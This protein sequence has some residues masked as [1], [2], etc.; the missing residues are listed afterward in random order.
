MSVKGLKMTLADKTS[1]LQNLEETVETL[2]LKVRDR[3]LEVEKQYLLIEKHYKQIANLNVPDDAEATDTS[4]EDTPPD[5][6]E[7]GSP[8]RMNQD[9][10]MDL[11]TSPLTK[12]QT[13]ILQEQAEIFNN[14]NLSPILSTKDE[15][16]LTPMEQ[17]SLSAARTDIRKS[18]TTMARPAQG[19]DE[20]P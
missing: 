6:S 5:H 1:K 12:Q 7:D 10:T 13:R 4:Y 14:R 11:H 2:G 16:D 15:E 19:F 8:V 17:E 9:L 18:H 20:V 3:M